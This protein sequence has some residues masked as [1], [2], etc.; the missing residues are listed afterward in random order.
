MIH[1]EVMFVLVAALLLQAPNANNIVQKV[2][3]SDP[4]GLS[5]SEV[6]ARAIIKD[7]GGATRTLAFSGHSRRHDPPLSK[8]LVRFSAP[9]DLAGVGFLQIQK[10]DADDE[11]FLFLPELKRSRRIAG[12]SRTQ[13]FVGTDFNYADLDRR[14]LRN[15]QATIKG[16]ESI[17]KFA[18][19]KLEVL[20]KA[21]DAVYARLELWVRKDNNVPLKWQMYSKSGVLL[22][23]LVAEEVKRVSGHWYITRSLMTNHQ[24]SRTTELLLDKVTPRDD[25]PD[26]EFTVRNLEKM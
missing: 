3:D 13:A 17:G 7:S 20:P 4:W 1:N 6:T 15:S 8:G 9:A 5:G 10:K 16:D 22:K 18:C 12:N 2:L 26:D 14:D 24:D 23:T 19:W 11:R 21:G 25:I